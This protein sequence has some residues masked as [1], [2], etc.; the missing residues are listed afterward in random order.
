MSS[1]A[2]NVDS[3]SLVNDYTTSLYE[4]LITISLPPQFVVEGGQQKMVPSLT[5]GDI[6]NHIKSEHWHQCGK[7]TCP[8]A[9]SLYDHLHKCGNICYHKARLEGYSE[10]ECVKAYLTGLLHDIGKPGTRR[11]LGKHTAFKGHGLVGGAMLENFY[12]PELVEAFGLTAD[13]WAD[14]STCADVHMCS[15]FSQHTSV[16]HKFSANILPT[17]VKKM[18]SI[19]RTGDQLA[20]VPDATYTKT[21]DDIRHEVESGEDEYRSTLFDEINF[22]TIEK[23]KGVLILLQ[24]GSATG[25]STFAKRLIQ[26]F[27]KEKCNHINR[28]WYMVHWTLK[29]NGEDDDI[30]YS[31]ITPELYQ[32]CY[33]M[34]I[35]SGK[36]WAPQMNQ[37]MSRDIFDGLQRGNIVIVDTLATMFDSIE[38]II[39]QVAK[40]AYR[41][42]FWLHRNQMITDEESSNRLGMDMT[43][44][45]AAHGDTS[46]YNPFNSR[47]N[48]M[49]S[50]SGSESEAGNN[51]WYLQTHLSLSIG[52]SNIKSGLLYHL[53]DK[54]H[55]MYNYNQSIPRVP[56]LEQT[57][58]LSLQELVQVLKD[59]NGIEEFFTQYAYTVSTYV[60]DVVGIKYIDGMNQIWQPK[61]AREARGRFY[62]VGDMAGGK[63]VPMK[64]TLQRGIE[65]L[66]KAHLD[67]GITETQ[68]VD[69]KSLSKLDTVQ[70][71]IMRTFS[72]V[73]PINSYLTG[74]VD[75]SLLI[76]NVYPKECEQYPI[77]KHLALTHGDKFTKTIVNHCIATDSPIVTVSTQGTLFIGEEMQD[78][79]LTSVQP[80]IDY[81]VKSFDSWEQMAP[82]LVSKVL[83]YY[84]S[85]KLDNTDMVNMCFESYCKNRISFTGRLHTELA[86]GYDHNGVNLLGAM[87]QGRYI[88]HFDLPRRVFKQPF[89]YN[90]KNTMDVYR[91][92][93][94]LDEVVLGKRTMDQFLE[95]F[96]IDEFTSRVVHPEGF[97]LL[98]PI[99]GV[100]DY[101]KIKTQMYYKCHKIRP[102]KMQELLLLP[103]VCGTYYPIL[104]N[105]HWFFDN[106]NESIHA[107]ITRTFTALTS[108][109][110]K[111]S[112]FY[113][114]QNPKARQRMDE[115]IDN[116]DNNDKKMVVYKMMLNNKDNWTDIVAL[117]SGIT[118]DIY[119]TQS[120]EMLIFTKGLLMKVEPWRPDWT[121]RLDALFATF[122]DAVNSLYGIVI[123]FTN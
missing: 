93:G 106:L 57:T 16:L 42:S 5:F 91:L 12:T 15:Y 14:I 81:E 29:L 119:K 84:T 34:Y 50:I 120:E 122:D 40:D 24:G 58:D 99:D 31:N 45:L 79:F 115:V 2:F 86:V 65:V 109:I 113:T 78:Y 22:S 43:S 67:G 71:M 87:N 85:M 75:G 77:I 49:K 13:D 53:T 54:I 74:K 72:G 64:D 90:I 30:T 33:K 117:F 52:W 32:R 56:V 112:I 108:E 41:I 107:L 61:W 44:Q 39:P 82:L 21:L 6:F 19:L 10:K 7:H 88:P 101:A 18:L 96:D 23:K 94:E 102:N 110:H 4:L 121:I 83:D 38:T 55:H 60:P 123:G 8:H 76:L 47:I 62:Y 68:D 27:G 26:M 1:Y 73:N 118:M 103:E 97:V 70:Q 46:I 111:G 35:D 3:T 98:T 114:K 9:E 51:D 80:V 66:T 92:M 63:V 11:L 116:P 37:H 95:N 105:L 36:K 89:Y 59:M 20:L 104:R 17:P 100:Y 69:P 28:D 48:W 25:K